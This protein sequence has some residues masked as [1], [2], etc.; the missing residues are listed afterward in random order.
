[1]VGRAELFGRGWPPLLKVLDKVVNDWSFLGKATK[2]TL[3]NATQGFVV[4]L[5]AGVLLSTIGLLVKP[6]NRSIGRLATLLNSIPW[7]AIGPLTVMVISSSATPVVFAVLAVFFS[8][9]VT[10]SSGL[11]RVEK[12]HL[13]LF[14]TLG[15]K[16]LSTFFRL[17]CR[18]AIPSVV[19]AAK[20]GAPAAMFG[21]VFGEWFGTTHTGLGLVMVSALQNYM[22]L[23]L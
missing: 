8:S 6:L 17:E 13:D 2:I 15:A 12:S 5:A 18:V 1:M 16:R 4:G 21:A 19:Y 3:W 20:L 22:T 23:R 7:I 9:F 14:R 11:S 10:I